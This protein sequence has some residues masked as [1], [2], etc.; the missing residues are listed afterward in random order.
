MSKLNKKEV[1]EDH[2]IIFIDNRRGLFDGVMG[3]EWT[4]II[5]WRKG[6][7]NG[8][9]GKQKMLSDGG[10]PKEVL[11]LTDKNQIQKPLEIDELANIITS[12]RDF[13]S[14]ADITSVLKPYGLRTD[15]ISD[16]EKYNLDPIYSEKETK[17]I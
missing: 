7:D 1:K 8:L 4:N 15:V 9:G 2:Q 10:S 16:Y 12:N 5:L 6:Y 14:L 17:M 3:A 11:L 13:E